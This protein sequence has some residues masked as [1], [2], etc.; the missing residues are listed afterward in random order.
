MNAAIPWYK[1]KIIVGAAVSILS[2]VLVTSG[3]LPDGLNGQDEALTELV[4]TGV[5][6]AADAVVIGSRVKQKEPASIV[7]TAAQAHTA[8]LDN[9]TVQG[10]AVSEHDLWL[11]RQMAEDARA[12][13]RD[14]EPE[15]PWMSQAEAYVQ[16]AR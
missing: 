14:G 12:N 9:L 5:G 10:A 6:L 11:D 1:S 13:V 16:E 2:K 4:V 3:L 8:A 15:L 7:A